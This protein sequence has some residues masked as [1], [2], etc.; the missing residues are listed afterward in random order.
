[1]SFTGLLI[2]TN[3]F[4]TQSAPAERSIFSG[5]APNRRRRRRTQSAEP[6]KDNPGKNDEHGD[7][8]LLVK[9]LA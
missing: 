4:W 3:P 8:A 2:T 6:Q 1:M 9:R 5:N 7:R